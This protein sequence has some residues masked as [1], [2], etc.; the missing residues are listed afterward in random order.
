MPKILAALTVIGTAA[1]LWVG[2]GIIVHGLEELGLHF[3]GHQIE[4]VA[5]AVAAG[6][7]ALGGALS[8]LTTAIL[9]AITGI[10]IGCVI[11]LIVAGIGK[12]KS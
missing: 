1:M 5:G 12:I 2:G 7:S 11:A 10:V 3:P 6:A 8:W 9:Y 4:T